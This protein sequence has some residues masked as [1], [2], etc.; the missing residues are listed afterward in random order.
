MSLD[1]PPDGDCAGGEA[2][3]PPLLPPELLPGEPLPCFD[4]L[5]V[6]FDFAG[7]VDSAVFVDSVD[8][9]TDVVWAVVL[10]AAACCSS[11]PPQPVTASAN[12]AAPVISTLLITRRA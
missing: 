3:V 9:G 2:G 7:V 11:S 6:F 10:G 5:L 1:V 8:V 12:A 4:D